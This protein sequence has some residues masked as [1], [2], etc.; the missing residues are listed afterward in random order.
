MRMKNTSTQSCF[1]ACTDD[2]GCWQDDGHFPNA[3]TRAGERLRARTANLS[4]KFAPT[5]ETG[6]P[7]LLWLRGV[8]RNRVWDYGCIPLSPTRSMNCW[9]GDAQCFPQ[10]NPKK[11][12]FVN[13]LPTAELR[14]LGRQTIDREF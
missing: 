3:R 11:N 9:S 4:E 12:L 8:L 2:H 14:A 10:H 7:V 6:K 13:I 1:C 5:N